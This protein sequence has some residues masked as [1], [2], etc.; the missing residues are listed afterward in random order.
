MT[1]NH[2]I[3]KTGLG[4]L[5]ALRSVLILV[6]GVVSILHRIYGM[7][8]VVLSLLLFVQCKM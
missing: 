2:M 1:N 5:I 6:F 3:A 4:T 8:T 7:N